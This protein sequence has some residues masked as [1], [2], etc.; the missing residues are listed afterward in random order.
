MFVLVVVVLEVAGMVER[1][2]RRRVM[3]EGKYVRLK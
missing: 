2:E 1:Y 3:C